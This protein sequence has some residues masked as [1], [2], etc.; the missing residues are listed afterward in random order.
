MPDVVAASLSA[1][2]GYDVL[3]R[4]AKC[5]LEVLAHAN[6][7]AAECSSVQLQSFAQHVVHAT[8]QMQQPRRHGNTGLAT[9]AKFTCAFRDAV[10][11]AGANG[12]DARLLRLLAGA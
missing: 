7:F 11:L 12:L 4:A 2:V 1:L 3:L 10:A 6:K 8:E 5:A 9:E